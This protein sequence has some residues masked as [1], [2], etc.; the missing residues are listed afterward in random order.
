MNKDYMKQTCGTCHPGI[1]DYTVGGN[2]KA[3]MTEKLDELQKL[4][5]AK[6]PGAV[7]IGGTRLTFPFE[8]AQGN[9]VDVKNVPLEAYVAACNYYMLKEDLE[10]YSAGAHNPA[11]TRALLDES[12]KRLK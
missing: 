11:Y 2:L 8:D 10:R 7:K 9:R 4:A 3:E 6:V 5:V 12:L 1:T